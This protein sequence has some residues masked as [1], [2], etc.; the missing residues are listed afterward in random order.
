MSQDDPTD[1][2]QRPQHPIEARISGL[3]IDTLSWSNGVAGG[4][5]ADQDYFEKLIGRKLPPKIFKL[6]PEGALIH[7]VRDGQVT[8]VGSIA[9]P[10][11]TV[12]HQLFGS[13]WIVAAGP[14]AH[15]QFGYPWNPVVRHPADLIGKH[16]YHSP[17]CGK[18]IKLTARETDYDSQLLVMTPR[19]LWAEDLEPEHNPMDDQ[20]FLGIEE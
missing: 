7:V 13:G 15:D 10:E 14:L 4:Y 12:A 16:Y 20:A 6:K 17:S 11:E 2:P 1:E 8:K 19:D 18:V 9:L 5:I 3:N